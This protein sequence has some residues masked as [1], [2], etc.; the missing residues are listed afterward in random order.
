MTIQNCLAKIIPVLWLNLLNPL[1][2]A[3]GSSLS[4]LVSNYR[5]APSPQK[6]AAIE[7]YAAANAA[8]SE[9]PLAYFALGVAAL[10]QKDYRTA[11]DAL[12]K[13]Q[14]RL[15]KIADYAAYYL[16]AA[17]V[18]AKDFDGINAELEPVQAME[19]RSPL[20]GKAWLVEARAKSYDTA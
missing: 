12:K 15:P 8:S 13:V 14:G 16:A 5:E 10:E 18:D 4:L 19:I 20:A 6:R 3:G 9:G 11:V 7:A 2:S 1:W 17:R